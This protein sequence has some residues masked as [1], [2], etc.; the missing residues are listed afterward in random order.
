M[1]RRP[2]WLG[3]G[4]ALCAAACSGGP[5]PP[6]SSPRT[7]AKK[8]AEPV[9]KP[10]YPTPAR[11]EVHPFA[12]APPTATMRLANGHC[13]GV[14]PNGQRWLISRRSPA[15]VP[16]FEDTGLVQDYDAEEY[17][18]EDPPDDTDPCA[19]FGR[20]ASERLPEP[21][22]AIVRL[23]DGFGFI[24]TS[25]TIHRARSPL[26]P[27][28][29][30]VS[31]REPVWIARGYGRTVL[32]V[33]QTGGLLRFDE[34]RGFEPV[35]LGDT[36]AFDLAVTRRQGA[37][38]LG[39]PEVILTSTDGGRSFRRAMA[40]SIGTQRIQRARDG[41]ILID[42]LRDTLAWSPAAPDVLTSAGEDVPDPPV[43]V[44][45]ERGRSP[46]A[47][48]VSDARGVID[49]D[50]YVGV[51]MTD[52]ENWYVVRGRLGG[53]LTRAKT[54]I[55]GRYTSSVVVAAR[56]PHVALGILAW[57]EDSMLLQLRRSHDGGD[58][59]GAPLPMT[60]AQGMRLGIAVSQ[61][62][63]VL[64]TGACPGTF[65]DEATCAGGPVVLRGD[66]TGVEARVEDLPERLL[67]PTFSP[68]GASAYFLGEDR[69]S[70]LTLFVSH[71][72]GA[73]FERRTLRAEDPDSGNDTS[74][75]A[76]PRASLTVSETGTLGLPAWREDDAGNVVWLTADADGKNLKMAAAPSTGVLL[77]GF[78]ERVLAVDAGYPKHEAVPAWESLDG[79]A[80]W[81]ELETP[82][83][84]GDANRSHGSVAC[85]AGGCLV[86]HNTTRIGW[87]GST[88]APLDFD[89]PE[90]EP[91]ER[92]LRTAIVCEPRP[93]SSWTRIDDI[94][95]PDVLPSATNA[96]R[97]RVAWMLTTH[98]AKTGAAGIASAVLPEPTT[99]DADAAIVKKQL[100]AP[101]PA[102]K[103]WTFVTR[104]QIE[105]AAMAR[106]TFPPPPKGASLPRGQ[107][108]QNL[109]I[110]WENIDE[111]TSVRAV[112]PD[113]GTYGTSRISGMVWNR[114]ALYLDVLSISPKGIFV[115][116]AHIDPQM[117]FVDSAGKVRSFEP[118][119]WPE[120]F[121][122]RASSLYTEA[123][124]VDGS[125]LLTST[126][127]FGSR[128]APRSIVLLRPPAPSEGP[129]APWVPFAGTI[130]PPPTTGSGTLSRVGWT[131]EGSHLAAWVVAS[132][133]DHRRARAWLTRPQADGTLTAPTPLPTPYD[134]PASPRPC[135]AAEHAGSPRLHMPL[136]RSGRALF[137]GTRHPVII[138]DGTPPRPPAAL[139]PDGVVPQPGDTSPARPRPPSPTASAAS[140]CSPTASSSAAPPRAPASTPSAPPASPPGRSPSSSS[141]ISAMPGSSASSA[142]RTCP[143]T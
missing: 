110:A 115:R 101:V 114:E 28:T 119:D 57:S 125:F 68:D 67:S 90:V 40:P 61:D 4:I 49:G 58:T 25:G 75:Q 84:L 8:A 27:I 143:P 71:D 129:S 2:G 94:A 130:A 93:G 111:G 14:E 9:E 33:T 56:G 7:A 102:G 109:E 123:L 81:S 60:P 30:R 48:E 15:Q 72:G 112:I 120:R 85:G 117:F 53:P 128:E 26:G 140:S 35:D 46:Q 98:D 36:F 69:D 44:T 132:S 17:P 5:A 133:P 21:M 6:R 108:L 66:S 135:T 52:N 82:A 118:P 54:P 20:A 19:G 51:E 31:P 23:P 41:R 11:W 74:F 121:S 42:G 73:S 64:L 55:G 99:P 12:F 141:A 87:G 79:G 95:D 104:D 77:A 16:D 65:V 38:V 24:G 103:R 134:L 76:A 63:T 127:S 88:P 34:E 39:A 43:S 10:P 50:R 32:A 131:Y 124:N 29:G 91:A 96:A 18:S 100:L 47:E 3:L 45:I 37:V 59:F 78:G 122:L 139:G 116:G 136:H 62:G 80:S 22:S 1:L 89:P 70:L 142:R 105:G 86:S 107:R 126:V 83:V 13:L 92:G 106:A 97:G 113:A 138:D 137:P